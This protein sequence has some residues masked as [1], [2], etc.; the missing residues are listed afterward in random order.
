MR[1]HKFNTFQGI[2]G[3]SI[4]IRVVKPEVNQERFSKEF[5]TSPGWIALRKKMRKGVKECQL[6]G[7]KTH[8]LICDHIKELR[9]GG[10]ALSPLN[11]QVICY[12]CHNK[13]TEISK[14]QRKWDQTRAEIEAV[15]E[16]SH[17]TEGGNSKS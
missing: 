11:I 12:P 6:C 4:G 2:R 9:D 16:G 7:L 13:K 8:R 15:L 3:F 10:E 17:A 5:Y 14:V 1:K